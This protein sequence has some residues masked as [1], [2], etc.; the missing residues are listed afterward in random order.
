VSA[1][2]DQLLIPEPG[3]VSISS[4]DIDLFKVFCHLSGFQNLGNFLM[5]RL[6][7]NKFQILRLEEEITFQSISQDFE[8]L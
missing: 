1:C 4:K 7:L 8:R 3:F 2:L 5:A 6:A